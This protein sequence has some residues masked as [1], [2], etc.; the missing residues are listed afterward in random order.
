MASVP[1]RQIESAIEE[2]ESEVAYKETNSIAV[3]MN[4]IF[5]DACENHNWYRTDEYSIAAR[6]M[7]IKWLNQFDYQLNLSIAT[8]LFD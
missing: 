4:Q 6:E 7:M 5:F 3:D 1:L 2:F 8:S